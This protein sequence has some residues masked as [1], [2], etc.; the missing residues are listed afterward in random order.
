MS[1]THPPYVCTNCDADRHHWGPTTPEDFT[2]ADGRRVRLL[3]RECICPDDQCDAGNVLVKL[4][5]PAD[6]ET[7]PISQIAT[8]ELPSLPR[9]TA[10]SGSTRPQPDEQMPSHHLLEKVLDGL[11]KFDVDNPPPP[12]APQPNPWPGTAGSAFDAFWKEH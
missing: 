10:C 4:P 11:R 2:T 8:P 3:R 5:T 12:A 7:E 9:R 6:A 1:A